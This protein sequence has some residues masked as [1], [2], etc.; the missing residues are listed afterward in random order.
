MR[1]K[2]R[3]K[4]RQCL[5]DR[6]WLV[7]FLGAVL[8][9]LFFIIVYTAAVFQ[10]HVQPLLPY[11]SDA[12]NDGF[13]AVIFTQLLN[14]ISLL[15]IASTFI[16]Y[17]QL[18]HYFQVL[19][20]FQELNTNRT[21]TF[22]REAQT[23]IRH[24]MC[25]NFRAFLVSILV[26]LSTITLAN[27]SNRDWLVLHTVGAVVAATG[28]CVYAWSMVKMCSQLSAAGL[29]SKPTSLIIISAL[30][31]FAYFLCAAASGASMFLCPNRAD[32]F[33]VP[34]R[35]QWTSQQPGYWWHVLAAASEY[36]LVCNF[37]LVLLCLANRMR[38]F[39]S[40]RL[41]RFSV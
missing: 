28:M 26:S 11:I 13:Q 39:K 22:N 30:G 34:F 38:T 14:V 6:L 31:S 4:I 35:A 7:P 9:F 32:F 10:G 12:G 33:L 18:R 1:S 29:E 17:Q 27:F 23:S 41:I 5:C 16:R 8:L 21:T 37:G 40:W 19:M 24:F 15:V 36:V 25:I 3:Q 2:W 20:E